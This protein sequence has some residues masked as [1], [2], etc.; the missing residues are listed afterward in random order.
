MHRF[1]VS[2]RLQNSISRELH[3]NEEHT[4]EAHQRFDKHVYTRV[5]VYCSTFLSEHEI[6]RALIGRADIRVPI[7]GWIKK[8]GFDVTDTLNWTRP[9]RQG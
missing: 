4:K 3:F 7:Y 9:D 1:I 8:R 5:F 6:R 2:I